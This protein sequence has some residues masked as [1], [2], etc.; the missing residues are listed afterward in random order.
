MMLT[1][2]YRA[3]S[4]KEIIRMFNWYNTK[5][6]TRKWKSINCSAGSYHYEI[7]LEDND[8]I[9]DYIDEIRN[10]VKESLEN[11]ISRL[12]ETLNAVSNPK[13]IIVVSRMYN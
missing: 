4:G 5:W 1:F 9:N 10:K 8:D 6:E 3:E 11:E 7:V 12:K 2:C 13:S